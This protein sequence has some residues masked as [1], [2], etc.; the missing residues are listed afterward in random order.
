MAIGL[1]NCAV[2]NDL[3]QSSKLFH[4]FCLK[5][6][7]A[8]ISGLLK[9]SPGDLTKDNTADDLESHLTVISGTGTINGFIVC[10]SKM[11]RT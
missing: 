11:Q 6:S 8:Y 10:V 3:R 9:E 5:I 1:L 4:L 7:V 2:A